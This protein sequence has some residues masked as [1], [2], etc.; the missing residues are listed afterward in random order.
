M[1]QRFKPF[2]VSVGEPSHNALPWPGG[3]GTSAKRGER[4]REKGFGL[5]ANGTRLPPLQS[6]GSDTSGSCSA[7]GVGCFRV[8]ASPPGFSG[9]GPALKASQ[10]VET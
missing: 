3:T 6:V 10:G 7:D 9:C 2:P 8:R 1:G 5:L 4:E